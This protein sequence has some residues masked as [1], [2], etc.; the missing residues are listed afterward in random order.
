V[1]LWKGVHVDSTR[2]TALV[3][4][5]FYLI[6]FASIP[7]VFLLAPVLDHADYITGSRADTRLL[8][9]CFLDL[10]NA[11]PASAPRWRCFRWS[12]G[13]RKRSRS[14]LSPPGCSKPPS[15]ASA[16]RASWPW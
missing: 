2:R 4:G 10:V 16:W 6:A 14:A 11:W 7:A 13:R 12:S 9:G 3:G 15:S 8:W 5:L 1:A